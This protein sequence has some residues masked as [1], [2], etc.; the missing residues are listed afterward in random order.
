[1]IPE[2]VL[3]DLS[4]MDSEMSLDTIFPALGIFPG[5]CLSVL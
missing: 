5:E 1:M 3:G 4:S 2:V